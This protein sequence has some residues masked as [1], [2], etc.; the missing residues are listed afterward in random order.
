MVE[1]IVFDMGNVLMDFAPDY[2]L[3]QYTSDL[4]LIKYLKEKIFY[5]DVW[6]SLD[7]GDVLFEDA[8]KALIKEIDDG[9]HALV[10]DFFKTWYL[11][12]T[13]RKDMLEYVKTLKKKGFNI[14]LLSN[15]APL[16]HEYKDNY[17][18]FQYFDGFVLSGD[19]QMS[20]PDEAIYKHLLDK[21][22]LKAETCLFVDDKEE[23]IRT[24][25][26]LGFYGY[27][28]NGNL[29]RFKDFLNNTIL[30]EKKSN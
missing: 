2:I 20:K 10:H 21:Y 22:H 12:K 25:E 24:A 16:F 3:S 4:D 13:E 29:H 30:H 17:G 15:V 14:Y 27:H 6:G 26:R 9:N 19:I 11:H 7:N 23:N 1:N 28:F 5:T 8:A 18:V